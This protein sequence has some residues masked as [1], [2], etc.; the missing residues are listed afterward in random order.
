MTFSSLSTL[1]QHLVA[2]LDAAVS[3]VDA[4]R[5]AKELAD[6]E[7]DILTYRASTLKEIDEKI[8]ILMAVMATGHQSYAL[9]LAHSVKTDLAY[10]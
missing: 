6:C 1:R 7:D 9:D 3:D 8:A 2:A 4:D 5:L 10:L